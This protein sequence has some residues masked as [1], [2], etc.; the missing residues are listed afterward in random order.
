MRSATIGEDVQQALLRHGD[1]V[2]NRSR[3]GR[4]TPITQY[5][6]ICLGRG[7][8]PH[9]TRAMGPRH[10]ALAARMALLHRSGLL[11]RWLLFA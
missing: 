6:P 11:D 4:S 2:L 7:T 10:G 1:F 3:R 8:G 9:R 5:C